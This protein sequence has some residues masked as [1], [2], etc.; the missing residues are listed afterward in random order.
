MT[1]ALPAAT[2]SADAARL[3]AELNEAVERTG[4]PCRG[5]TDW[6]DDDRDVRAEAAVACQ[7]CAVLARCADYVAAAGEDFGVWAGVDRTPS[8]ATHHRRTR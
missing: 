5:R 7:R 3:H 6:T 4:A 8:A 2:L 1:A